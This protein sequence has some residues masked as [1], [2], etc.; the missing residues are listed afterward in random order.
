MP[1]HKSPV[2]ILSDFA[3]IK[4]IILI[5]S[6]AFTQQVYANELHV[7]INGKAIHDNKKDFNEDNWGLGFEYDFKEKAKW[8]NFI[9]GGFFKDSLSNTSKYLGG[10][11]KRRFLFTDDED[12][13]H[14]DIGLNA[15]LMTRKDY[16]GNKPFFGALPFLSVGTDKYAVNVTYIPAINP[17]YEALWFFQ[18]SVKL[19]KW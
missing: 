7:I 16:K 5:L 12:G 4:L 8:I 15:F 17:K 19:A 6:L 2:V 1:I 9:N 18:A 14:V 13:L 10:G 3:M 11:S